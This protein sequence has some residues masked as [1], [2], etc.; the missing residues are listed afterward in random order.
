MLVLRGRTRE[1]KR[2]ALHQQQMPPPAPPSVEASPSEPLHHHHG[3]QQQLQHH[4]HQQQLVGVL[5]PLAVVTSVH[6]VPLPQTPEDPSILQQQLP[7]P[8]P[9]THLSVIPSGI[10]G[11]CPDAGNADG[12]DG[13]NGHDDSGEI[14]SQE[15]SSTENGELKGGGSSGKKN[16]HGRLRH[17]LPF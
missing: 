6:G 3:H 13:V 1:K 4:H 10:D 7:P 2:M 5:D 8:P 9:S 11:E 15:A 12:H 14:Q 16:S 17:D